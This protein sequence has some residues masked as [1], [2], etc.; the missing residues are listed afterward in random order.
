MNYNYDDEILFCGN[1]AGFMAVESC[2]GIYKAFEES[3][4]IPGKAITSSGSTLFASLYY[5]I[6]TTKWFEAMM[7]LSKPD[8][9]IKFNLSAF[10]QTAFSK[11]NYFID[12][13]PVLNLL[14]KHMTGNAS[15][16]VSTSVTKTSDWTSHMKQV[17]PYWAT[18]AT[19]IPFIFKPVKIGN[20]YWAD[21]GVL[22]NLP[23]P[24]FID[25]S[26]YKH[27]Y[28]FIAPPTRYSTNQFLP[29]QLFNLLQAIMDREIEQLFESGF[30][31]LKNVTVIRPKS[32]H[33]GSL[34]N[35]SP[36]FNLRNECYQIT[37]SILK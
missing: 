13:D 37:K 14:K 16:R 20:E 23:T 6:E 34:F 10:I 4:I 9:F 15:T 17:T 35:W 7:D 30:F 36:D 8:D 31:A 11:N 25:A 27:I 2:V 29:C 22:N 3:G 18:A 21:G 5:S 32:N 24:S 12:N 19:S 28:V 1:G 26:T 33:N